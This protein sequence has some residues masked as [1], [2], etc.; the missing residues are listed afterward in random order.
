[1]HVIF[2]NTGVQVICIPLPAGRRFQTNQ[3]GQGWQ[4]CRR[5]VFSDKTQEEEDR[6]FPYLQWQIIQGRTSKLYL[7]IDSSCGDADAGYFCA[8]NALAGDFEVSLEGLLDIENEELPGI[9]KVEIVIRAATAA[10]GDPK[11]VHMVVDFG[12][13]RT[14]ALILEMTGEVAQTPQM[15]PF[16]L[17]NRYHLDAWDENGEGIDQPYNRWFSSKTHWAITPFLF[18]PQLTKTEYYTETVKKMIGKKQISRT[19]ES[20]VRANLFEDWSMARLGAEVNDIAQLMHA[21]GD[22]RTSVSS[23]KRYMWADDES[24]LEGAN[25]YMADPYDRFKT[26]EYACKLQGSL[27]RFIHEDDRDMLLRK[28]NLTED[29]Y[30][31]QIPI[32]PRHA[33]R[34]MMSAALYEI[35]SQAYMYVNSETY[36]RR[37]GDT[38]RAREIRS[39]TLTFPSGMYQEERDRFAAQA[40]KAINMFTRTVGKHQKEQPQLTLS[41]DEASAVHLTYIWSE[42]RMLG[43]NPALWFQVLHQDS[44]QK[45][46]P[47]KPAEE[48]PAAEATPAGRR[49]NR[50]AGRPTRAPRP[51][52]G[53]PAPTP[54]QLDGKEV[55]IACIDI[56]G[57]TSDL[58]IARYTF[59]PGIDD[60][61]QGQVLH[62]DGISLGGDQLVKRMLEKIVVPTFADVLA[63]EPEDIQLLFGPEVPR[64]REFRSQRV[65]WVNRLFVPLTEAYF[66]NAVNSVEN[67]EISHTDPEVVD[68]T[69]LESL[70]KMFDKL[71]GSG[72]YSI[73]QELGL[74]YKKDEF[75][76]VVHEVFDDLIFDFCER[77][78]EHGADVVLLAGQPTKLQY[79]RDLV[80]TYVPL[81]DARIISMFNHYAGN[82]YP[83]Q[84]PRGHNPGVII[85]PKSAV[86][87]G[88]GIE[89]LARHGL[90]PQSTF[91]MKGKET[92]NTYTWGVMTDGTSGI[93]EE[94]ILFRPADDQSKVET[95]EFTTIAQR[96]II[97]RKL[98]PA[99][100]A[101]AS[102][103]YVFKMD[104]GDRIGETEVNIKLRRE[105][106]TDDVEEHIQV[107]SVT[108]SVAGDAAILGENVDFSWRTLAD[109]RFFLD[110]GGLDNIEMQEA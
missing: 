1:M 24:W 54:Q 73:H 16:E 17:A 96:V 26:G 104:T 64:N 62:Q 65:N 31:A 45:K 19:R 85:D 72:Y 35:L 98:N 49:R 22:I 13:S 78:V 28:K 23:P 47:E 79:I 42:L 91:R 9:P 21:E 4:H 94:R 71:R 46:Q 81:P 15:M 102:P 100:D 107:E 61:I 38:G 30:A 89:F 80:S 39:F 59:E 12:N 83:Y 40:Q 10:G 5:R 8:P 82:W 67:E 32:K 75:E 105:R 77:I 33:P 44:E 3:I 41:I 6:D 11:H 29:D 50:G 99:E 25:W 36:R 52:R 95:T 20:A 69:V 92:E 60:S 93:R 34:S 53:T 86:V 70:E 87:V 68:P 101:Q 56:G 66:E 84:D 109:E 48:E 18:P 55:R 110:T 27:L 43:Q 88:A 7:A 37:S 76:D 63:M 58:M 90:L 14:G 97:G 108:G 74:E 106:A 103:I 2:A 51:G 57:G